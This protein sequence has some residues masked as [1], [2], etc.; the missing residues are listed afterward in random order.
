MRTCVTV[1]VP[2]WLTGP[3]TVGVTEAVWSDSLPAVESMPA[4]ALEEY[5]TAVPGVVV[6]P[7]VIGVSKLFSAREVLIA[8]YGSDK[9]SASPAS[10]PNSPHSRQAKTTRGISAS[11]ANEAGFRSNMKLTDCPVWLRLTVA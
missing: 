7:A 11:Q 9:E 10:R 5:V 3:L 2:L 1:G 4:G 8:A 6:G